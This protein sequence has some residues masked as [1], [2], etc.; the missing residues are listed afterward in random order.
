LQ[1]GKIAIMV[2]KFKLLAFQVSESAA[3]ITSLATSANSLFE[4]VSSP[5]DKPFIIGQNMRSVHG[6]D[7]EAFLL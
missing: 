4:I 7:L 3:L 5:M 2:S 1:N 6:A